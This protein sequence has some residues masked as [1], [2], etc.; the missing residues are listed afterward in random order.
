MPMSVYWQRRVTEAREWAFIWRGWGWAGFRPGMRRVVLRGNVPR[1]RGFR[2]YPCWEYNPID[3]QLILSAFQMTNDTLPEYVARI[4]RF[5]PHAIQAY[6]SALTPLAR[7]LRAAGTKLEGLRCVLTCSETVF[8]GQRA[9]TRD[10]LGC[11]IFDH[12]GTTERNALVMQCEKLRYHVIPEYGILELIGPDGEPVEEAGAAGEIVATGFINPAMPLIRY[13]TG[14]VA[15]R[16]AAPC[17][18]GRNYEVLDRIAGRIQEY[19]V[20]QNRSLASAIWSDGPFWELPDR[21]EAYQYVQREPGRVVLNIEA[22]GGL[23][24]ASIKRIRQEF[25]KHYPRIEL[26]IHEVEHIP[27]TERGK[28]RYVVQHLSLDGLE[29]GVHA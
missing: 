17:S 11:S 13:R 22:K 8:S 2:P 10:V 16:G 12:Y 18:C 24:D 25:E 21:V 14:D 23:S 29:F 20:D 7:F 15:I 6:P 9:L 27:R 28:F 1:Q 5:R 26:L 4:R 3:Q 19:F